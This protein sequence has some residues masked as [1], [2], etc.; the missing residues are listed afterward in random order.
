MNT[1]RLLEDEI[2]H[3]RGD[4]EGQQDIFLLDLHGL[5]L[6]LNDDSMRLLRA[7]LLIHTNSPKTTT[8]TGSPA[9]LNALARTLN[10]SS[11]T[12]RG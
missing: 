10:P 4:E 3:G 6:S 11:V 9:I 1:V 12:V 2:P 5:P 7:C 8:I